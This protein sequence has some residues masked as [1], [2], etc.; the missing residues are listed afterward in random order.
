MNSAKILLLLTLF[1]LILFSAQDT[2]VKADSESS[3]PYSRDTCRTWNDA[4]RLKNTPAIIIGRLQKFT[5]WEKGKGAGHMFWQFEIKLDDGTAIP[6]VNTD[7]S[8]GESIPFDEYLNSDVIIYLSLI[9]IS[10]PTRP[11]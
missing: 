11:Y 5:P 4:E 8:D 3:S 2:R 9:H 10:E 7:K 1:G 6:V